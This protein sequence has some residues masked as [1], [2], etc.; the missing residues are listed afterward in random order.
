[1]DPMI[2]EDLGDDVLKSVL[3]VILFGNGTARFSATPPLCGLA[4]RDVVNALLLVCFFS[5]VWLC[6]WQCLILSH[7]SSVP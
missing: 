5:F 4:V 6:P 7:R 3:Q 2:W 1:M